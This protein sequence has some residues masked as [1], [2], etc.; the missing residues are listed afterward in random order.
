V[1]NSSKSNLTGG[2]QK[3][4]L[5]DNT[6]NLICCQNEFEIAT[7]EKSSSNRLNREIQA[8]LSLPYCFQ[9]PQSQQS[10]DE[11]FVYSLKLFEK[12]FSDSAATPSL[13]SIYDNLRIYCAPKPKNCDFATINLNYVA[14]QN[15]SAKTTTT[16][17][18]NFAVNKYFRRQLSNLILADLLG[19]AEITSQN[20]TTSYLAAYGV[21][22]VSFFVFIS[23]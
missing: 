23:S 19:T 3:S 12:H 2:S 17:A 4:K 22:V 21:F 11:L 14:C 9:Q 13:P 20:L 16:T 7:S 1:N 15:N 10:S 5:A 18:F 6:I 8:Y